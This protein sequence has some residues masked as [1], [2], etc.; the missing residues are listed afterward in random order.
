MN[1][2]RNLPHPYLMHTVTR[3]AF[4]AFG[5]IAMELEPEVLVAC[6]NGTAAAVFNGFEDDQFYDFAVNFALD[7]VME[8]GLSPRDDVLGVFALLADEN[9]DTIGEYPKLCV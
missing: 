4:E 7:E 8:C 1:E 2:Q 9:D 3:I 6:L 5:D